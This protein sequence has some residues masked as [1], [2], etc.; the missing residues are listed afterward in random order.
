M[1]DPVLAVCAERCSRFGDP[2]CYELE[3]TGP[4]DAPFVWAPCSECL[5][6]VGVHVRI[7]LDPDAVIRNLI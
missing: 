6:D 3:G 7:A 2:P 4:V 1:T 5:A